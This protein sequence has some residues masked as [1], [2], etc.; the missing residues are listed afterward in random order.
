MVDER[1]SHVVVEQLEIL[2]SGVQ[3]IK[4]SVYNS[5]KE[6]ILEKID[7][8]HGLLDRVE[9]LIQEV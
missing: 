9:E 2:T 8:L 7:K 4:T 5:S 6:E 1:V 3:D